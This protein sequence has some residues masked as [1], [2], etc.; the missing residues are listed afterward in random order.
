MSHDL[1]RGAS[2]GACV[3]VFAS[4]MVGA[5]VLNDTCD[6]AVNNSF[7]LIDGTNPGLTSVGATASGVASSCGG[8]SISPIPLPF[9]G[10]ATDVWYAYTATATCAVTFEITA[11]TLAFPVIA[12][13][14]GSAYQGS[15][16]CGSLPE[17][18]CA[19]A[20]QSATGAIGQALVQISLNAG[21]F[22][23]V[24]VSDALGVT[25]GTFTVDINPALSLSFSAPTGPGSLRIVNDC[26]VPFATYV[27]AIEL[28][29]GLTPSGWF[30]GLD[31]SFPTLLHEMTLGPPF[32]GALDAA[33]S[34][35]WTLP[36]IIPSNITLY[37]VTLT[38]DPVTQVP[39]LVSSV[40]TFT[41]L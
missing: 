21:D 10:V 5:Q 40:V 22:V 12:V 33:G 8:S 18:G 19:S 6:Q 24:Q 31:I 15:A 3:L 39:A 28:N 26:G 13:W 23:F 41:T 20:L 2:V 4:A 14:D 17:L 7:F 34:S 35:D 37:A 25:G 30:F 1:I 27:T 36:V 29:Q 16:S 38:L 32:I 11:S 9:P